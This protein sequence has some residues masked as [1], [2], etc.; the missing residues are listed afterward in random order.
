MQ[1]VAQTMQRAT[2]GMLG[3]GGAEHLFRRDGTIA[4]VVATKRVSWVAPIAPMGVVFCVIVGGGTRLVM[5]ATVVV[6]VVACTAVF[7]DLRGGIMVTP[8]L[9]V[10]VSAAGESRCANGYR[11]KNN[12]N[13]TRLVQ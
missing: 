3:I 11:R 2:V 7:V 1:V 6:A 12:Q 9:L 5:A 13:S 4:W 8:V 10:T